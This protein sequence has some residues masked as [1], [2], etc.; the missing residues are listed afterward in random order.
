MKTKQS[1]YEDPYKKELDCKIISVDPSGSL[2]NV[3]C[4]QTIFYPE[5]GGQPSDRG[6][7]GNTKVEYVIR[8]KE[9]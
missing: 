1:Y 6:T 7:L 2:I 9:K 3:I 4:D 8:L 5:G